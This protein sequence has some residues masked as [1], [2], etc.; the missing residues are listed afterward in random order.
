[1]PFLHAH[2]RRVPAQYLN[3]CI[4][5]GVGL[6]AAVD[7]GEARLALAAS[8]VN[9]TAHRTGLRGK[10]SGHL[11]KCSAAF[12]Q[13]VGEDRFK[14]LPALIKNGSVQSGFLPHFPAWLF[15]CSFRARGHVAR[16]QVF[17][18]HMAETMRDRQRGLV[19]PILTNARCFGGNSGNAA[20]GLCP[21]VRSAFLARKRLLGSF[22]GEGEILR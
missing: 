16:A 2:R 17:K 19:M 3:S 11:R 12:F 6:V 21:A 18:C 5:V 22:A 10:G 15:D 7:A 8:P 14:R 1:M 13:F 4:C 20:K 9:A